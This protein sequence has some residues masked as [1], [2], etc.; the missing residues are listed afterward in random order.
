[1]ASRQS[2]K[3]KILGSIPRL[4]NQHRGISLMVKREP[5][6]L[7]SSVRFRYPAPNNSVCSAVWLAHLLWEQRVVG[8]NPTTPTIY[9][10]VAQLV[11]HFLAKEDV[12][13][14]SLFARSRI[15]R[16][17]LMSCKLRQGFFASANGM[18]AGL[19]NQLSEGSNPSRGARL[20]RCSS[21]D[22][23]ILS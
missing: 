6:K 9:A 8:S 11:E 15:T 22:R 7:T 14:S 12:E 5:S 17:L 20:S 2:H 1:M 4:R 16:P 21:M 13:S 3:L 18:G 19:L 23:T 10:G